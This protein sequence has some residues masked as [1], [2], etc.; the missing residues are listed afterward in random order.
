[1]N[2]VLESRVAKSDKVRLSYF[3]GSFTTSRLFW[4]TSSVLLEIVLQRFGFTF[5][6]PWAIIVVGTLTRKG[7]GANVALRTDRSDSPTQRMAHLVDIRHTPSRAARENW[8]C[9]D[10]DKSQLSCKERVTPQSYVSDTYRIRMLTY[11]YLHI[12]I[13][14]TLHNISMGNALW[15][16]A[17]DVTIT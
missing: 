3:K 6:E 5:A 16:S 13:L 4:G 2:P 11:M 14:L 7:S 17:R 12:R 1:M 10:A 9:F 8:L 15:T